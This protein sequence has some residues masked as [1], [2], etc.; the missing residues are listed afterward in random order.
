MAL[1][2]II[3]GQLTGDPVATIDAIA[4]GITILLGKMS[5]ARVV[6]VS[7]VAGDQ[8]VEIV[9]GDDY[10]T[11]D[12]RALTWTVEDYSGPDV[13]GLTVTFGVTPAADYNAGSANPVFTATGSAAMSGDD[14][15]FSVELTATQ[16]ALL[17]PSPPA[18]SFGYIYQMRAT[19]GAG[20]KI[21]EALSSLTCRGKAI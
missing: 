3:G 13:T 5:G 11:A 7:P 15:V 14:A 21:T 19:S 9:Q 12:G 18:D 6:T 2:E 20:H 8:S 10:R 17:T 1:L 4:N 16:T